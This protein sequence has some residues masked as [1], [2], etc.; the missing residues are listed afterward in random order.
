MVP[1][2]LFL[3][4]ITFAVFVCMCL[5]LIQD[6]GHHPIKIMRKNFKAS[7]PDFESHNTVQLVFLYKL[8]IV[9]KCISH[10]V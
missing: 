3:G 8:H 7:C 4:G 10:T 6:F 1:D 2:G 9:F 5:I